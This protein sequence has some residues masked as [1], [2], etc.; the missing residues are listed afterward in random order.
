MA[1]TSRYQKGPPPKLQIL[2]KGVLVAELTKELKSE[3][4]IYTF[5][6]LPEFK[7]RKLAPLPG[8]PYSEFPRQSSELWPYFV[9]R[10]PDARRPEIQAWM[11]MK[12]LSSADDIRLIAELGAYSVTDPFEIRLAA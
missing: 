12:K 2:F 10:I 8:L 9:E 5:R 7:N 6:Y 4:P 11:K 1:F 3:G